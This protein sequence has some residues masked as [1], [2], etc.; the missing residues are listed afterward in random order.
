MQDE[1]AAALPIFDV[2]PAP[3]ELE[4]ELELEDGFAVVPRL[5]TEGD[6]DP[7]H[8]AAIDT[9]APSVSTHAAM[10]AWR[11]RSITAS[12]PAVRETALKQV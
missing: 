5:A 7:A 6:A 12:K 8:P 11:D 2:G 3:P 1:N 10:R 9:R 4:L